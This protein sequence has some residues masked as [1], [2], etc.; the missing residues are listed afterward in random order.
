MPKPSSTALVLLAANRLPLD[1]LS[2]RDTVLLRRLGE[3]AALDGMN[4][5]LVGG[6]VRDLLLGR[7]GGDLDLT[8]EG[9][10]VAFARRVAPGL[11]A[12]AKTHRRFGTATLLFA[13]EVHLDVTTARR[14]TYAHPG[15]LPAVRPSTLKEDLFRRDFTVNAMAVRLNPEG[16]GELVDPFGGADDLRAG[17]LRVLHPRSFEDDPTRILR[18]ARFAARFGFRME[19]E[20]RALALAA[21]AEG[22]LATVTPERIRREVFLGLEERDPTQVVLEWEALGVLADLHR[23]LAANAEGVRRSLE[24]LTWYDALGQPEQPNRPLL[25]LAATLAPLSAEDAPEVAERRLKLPP[26]SVE[27]LRACLTT[28]ADFGASLLAMDPAALTNRLQSAK[29]EALLY[30][31]SLDSW[32]RE[33]LAAYFTRLRHVR[34]GVTGDDLREAGYAPGPRMGEALRAALNEKRRGALPTVADEWAFLSA[35][36]GEQ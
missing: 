18:G 21:V 14:E 17:L 23:R 4:L 7:P 27:T 36:L 5:C 9:G 16:W 28:P 25:L 32:L 3:E 8:L 1:S 33:P 34:L 12:R 26:A 10:A 11:N 2:A 30:A 19:P 20:T 35:W 29:L 13:D 15:A 6:A 22:R 24:T 31:A